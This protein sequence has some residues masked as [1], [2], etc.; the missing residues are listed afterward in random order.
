M[1]EINVRNW[2]NETVRKVEL[3]AAVFDYPVKNHLIYEAVC[4]YQAAG[5]G[6]N[7][8][9]KNRTEIS[10]GGRKVWRQKGTGRARVGDNRSPLWRHGGTVHGPQP[11]DYSWRFP[12]KMRR[13][14]LRSVLAQKLRDGKLVCVEAFQLESHKTKDLEKAVRGGLG[15]EGRT[16]LMPL[17]GERSLV[18]AAR[19]NPG[20]AVVRALGVSVVDLLDADTVIIAEDAIGRLTEALSS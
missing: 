20:V 15:I 4:A 16:L 13:N 12:K 14:A 11:R 9:T 5:R 7:H 18:L 10:G 8:K 19:N 17:D 3:D 6:G 1:P 2:K